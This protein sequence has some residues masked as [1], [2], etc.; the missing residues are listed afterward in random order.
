MTTRKLGQS[1]IEAGAVAFGAWALGGWMWG[2]VEQNDSVRAL[3]AAID[4][5]MNLDD[6]ATDYGMGRSE[7]VVEFVENGGCVLAQGEARYR[8]RMPGWQMRPV[9][10]NERNER[11]EGL[12]EI[13]LDSSDPVLLSTPE[14]PHG[15]VVMEAEEFRRGNVVR[16]AAGETTGILSREEP[17]YAEY[18]W[19]VRS[20]RTAAIRVRYSSEDSRPLAVS[21]NGEPVTD[22]ACRVPTGGDLMWHDL[23]LCRLRQGKNVLRL[24][25]DGAFPFVDKIAAKRVHR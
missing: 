1:G 15:A 5:G 14:A 4:A 22:A 24:E 13:S 6:T 7:E 17:A 16:G 25:T 21:L 18:E 10:V 12:F 3:H 9:F 19:R 23:G 8:N 11:Y 20:E 2:G